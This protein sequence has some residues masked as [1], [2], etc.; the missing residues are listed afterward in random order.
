M[1]LTLDVYGTPA[2]QG[3]KNAFVVTPKGG[4]PP[5]AVVV[6]KNAP[7]LHSWR[8]TVANACRDHL[9]LDGNRLEHAVAVTLLFYLKRPASHYGT[10]RNAGILKAT[11]PTHPTTKPDIDKL[12]RSTLDAFTT[13]GV[14]R[15]DS[16]V[17]AL[18]VE[19][20][21]ADA[22]DPGVYLH[23]RALMP[24]A[25]PNTEGEA[26]TGTADVPLWP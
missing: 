1:A 24:S 15:D 14:Y 23:V 11:A 5:R 6:S 4:G 12:V 8:E 20:L 26:V 16:Q 13:A 18:V 17:V 10:G 25:V 21:Y 19:K 22:R 2:P 9:G 3:S 7:A